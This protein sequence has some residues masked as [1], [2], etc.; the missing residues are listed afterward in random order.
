MKTTIST[1]QSKYPKL[2]RST[3]SNSIY[4]MTSKIE[5]TKIHIGNEHTDIHH[6]IGYHYKNWEQITL[7]DYNGIVTLSN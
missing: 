5:G 6:P 1:E 4:L 2:M 7:I 3:K